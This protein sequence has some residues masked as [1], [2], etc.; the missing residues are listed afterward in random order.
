MLVVSQEIYV[1]EMTEVSGTAYGASH[2]TEA[3]LLS[4][5]NCFIYEREVPACRAILIERKVSVGG[6][7]FSWGVNDQSSGCLP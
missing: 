6:T 1:E 2:T 7:R 5:P 3:S 4:S